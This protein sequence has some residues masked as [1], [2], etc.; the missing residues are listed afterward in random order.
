MTNEVLKNQI[1]KKIDKIENTALLNA[2]FLLINNL[3]EVRRIE[4]SQ[5][6]SSGD[7][8]FIAYGDGME[9]QAA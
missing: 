3:E 2:I 4:R 5:P 7:R 1:T 9:P 6:E 8:D